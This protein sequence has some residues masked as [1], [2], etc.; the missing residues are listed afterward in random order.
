MEGTM[1]D[2]SSSAAMVDTQRYVA[3]DLEYNQPSG[4]IIQVGVAIGSAGQSQHEYVV[5]RW[6]LKVDEPISEF[7][8]QLTGITDE[9]CRAGVTLAQCAQELGKLLGEH[10][11][12]VNPVT[13]TLPLFCGV[14]N[15]R[16]TRPF[17]AVPRTSVF[18]TASG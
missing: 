16:F 12:F 1:Q 9:D 13:L 3:L 5:R 7:I 18:R 15:P 4:T 6:D 8:T 17:C 10:E 2:E 11:V 14:H